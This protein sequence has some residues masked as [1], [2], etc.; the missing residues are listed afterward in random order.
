M[1]SNKIMGYGTAF[2]A[3]ATIALALFT[4][5]ILEETKGFNSE[6]LGIS[7]IVNSPRIYHGVSYCPKLTGISNGETFHVQL[8]NY[9]PRPTNI[10]VRIISPQVK[11]ADYDNLLYFS[12]TLEILKILPISIPGETLTYPILFRSEALNKQSNFPK[13]LT[14][15]VE[16]DYLNDITGTYIGPFSYF[17][18]GACHYELDEETGYYKEIPNFPISQ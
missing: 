2:L 13:N 18:Y 8:N 10:R 6:V 17:S 15:S 9:G 4:Y 11:W 14:F 1:D 12:N 7:K 5:Q 3:L 16:Y